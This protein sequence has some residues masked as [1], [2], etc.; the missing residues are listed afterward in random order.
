MAVSFLYVRMFGV[1]VTL[2]VVALYCYSCF[3]LMKMQY[4]SI[5]YIWGAFC[6]IPFLM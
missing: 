2:Q 4:Q 3:I 5:S 6:L 1:E